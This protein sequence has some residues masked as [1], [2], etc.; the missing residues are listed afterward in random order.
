MKPWQLKKAFAPENWLCYGQNA[1]D[2]PDPVA[3]VEGENDRISIMDLAKYDHVMATIASYNEPNIIKKLKS[4]AKG[5]TWYLAFDNDPPTGNQPEGAGA[6]YTRQYGNALFG[7]GGDVRIIEISRSADEG[8]VD[9][10]DVLRAADD[11]VA[12]WKELMSSAKKIA[13]PLKAPER[14]PGLA[15][16]DSG[17]MPEGEDPFKFSSFEV[18][19]ELQDEK[20]LFWSKVNERLY[21]VTLKDLQLDKL[22]QIGGIEVAA[23]VAR[24]S[25]TASDGQVLFGTLKKRLIVEAGKR[26]LWDPDYLGQGFHALT[27][28]RMLIVV[29]G[30]AWVWDG[31]KLSEWTNPVISNR[32]I[33]WRRGYEW[34]DMPRVIGMV[35]NMDVSR[36]RTRSSRS[37]WSSCFSGVFPESSMFTCWRDG[38][39]HSGCN[40]FGRGGPICG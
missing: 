15:G 24:S 6:R 25:K 31:E 18:L 8:K 28:D 27:K 33:E 22:V 39:S 21:P 17:D 13:E 20:L 2:Q 9:I 1:L 11:P 36:V 29:G 32:L 40:R 35:R 30:H 26:Q 34:V 4:I 12:R 37:C 5:R 14:G 7:A 3:I 23:R 38:T 16:G 19:G 10:D